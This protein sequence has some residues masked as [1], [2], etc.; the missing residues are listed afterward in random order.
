MAIRIC[1]PVEEPPPVELTSIPL[2]ELT[3]SLHVVADPRKQPALA[4]FVRRVR[5]PPETGAAELRD[6]SS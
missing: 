2:T 3:M 4:P 6:L 1:F 5:S